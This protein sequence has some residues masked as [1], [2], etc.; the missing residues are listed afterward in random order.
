MKFF[1]ILVQ[2]TIKLSFVMNEITKSNN[3]MSW[4]TVLDLYAML[5]SQLQQ[6]WENHLQKHISRAV[7][8][9][10]C[11]SDHDFLWKKCTT[12]ESL[13]YKAD[14]SRRKETWNYH[15]IIVNTS[16]NNTQFV[17]S[18]LNNNKH[19]LCNHNKCKY[20]QQQ[21]CLHNKHVFDNNKKDV[22]KNMS[23]INKSI[24]QQ[25]SALLRKNKENKQLL[26]KTT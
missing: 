11:N 12:K 4:V 19:M 9:S 24:W 26:S 20:K 15:M 25:K 18:N 16:H 1:L 2:N 22:V 17:I 8:C 10:E 13:L 5:T 23:K 6:M 3:A 7:S 21:C 14:T